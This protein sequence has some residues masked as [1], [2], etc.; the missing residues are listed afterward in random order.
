LLGKSRARLRPLEP[1]HR[2]QALSK[3]VQDSSGRSD[4]EMARF[5]AEIDQLD[6][7]LVDL[8]CKRGD[9]VRKIQR[10]RGSQDRIPDREEQILARLCGQ[11]QGPYPEETLRRVWQALFEAAPGLDG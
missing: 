10:S 11:N 3:Q 5:R 4:D 1:P 2:R 9:L 7:R 8:L 6:S